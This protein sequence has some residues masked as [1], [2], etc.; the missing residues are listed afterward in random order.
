MTDTRNANLVYASA[1]CV[2]YL[3]PIWASGPSGTNSVAPV[4]APYLCLGWIDTGGLIFKLNAVYKDIMASGT[5]EPIRTVLQSAVKTF[6][7]NFLESMNPV[8]RA[9]YDDVPINAL[10]PSTGTHMASYVLP[11]VPSDNRYCF[12]FDSLDDD[13]EQRV[14]APLGKVTARGQDQLTQADAQQ[15]QMTLTLYPALIGSVRSCMQR[16]INYGAADLSP[17]SFQ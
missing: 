8:V 12:I 6:D 17:F 14:F 1:D 15:L 13:Q 7:V 2:G 5:L 16:F 10:A 4:V 3:A 9:L 11:D